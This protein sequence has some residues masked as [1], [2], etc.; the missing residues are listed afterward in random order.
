[1]KQ[2]IKSVVLFSLFAS[3]F[4]V[5]A[6]L[7]VGKLSPKILNGN[8]LVENKI[9]ANDF[10]EKR[11]LDLKKSD[12][13]DLAIFGSSHA[14]RGY[15]N[16]I[17]NNVGMRTLNLGSSSQTPIL[18]EFIYNNYIVEISPKI[19]LIDIYPILLTKNS[20]EGD[21]NVLPIFYNNLGFIAEGINGSDIRVINSLIYFQVFGN[22][23]N[24]KS[25]ISHN[26]KYVDGGYV[27]NFGVKEDKKKYKVTALEIK[28]KNIVALKNIVTDAEKKGIKVFLFQAPLPEERYKS[29]SNNKEINSIM[30]SIG[31]YYNYNDVGFLPSQY[32][33]DDSHINQKGVDVYNKWVID[34]IKENE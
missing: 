20:E 3:L 2:F 9:S 4:Y 34:K 8:I 32:F 22:A 26:D 14:Y 5:L 18:T 19:I 23:R 16:R 29:Y 13:I 25:R 15:D 10:S 33:M 28:E 31:K 12:S 1:M 24:V 11:Y 27:S 30:H 6:I 21:L 17:F 7:F